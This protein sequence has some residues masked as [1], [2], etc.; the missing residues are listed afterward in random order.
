MRGISA[1]AAAHP[2]SAILAL[3]RPLEAPKPDADEE[4]LEGEREDLEEPIQPRIPAPPLRPVLLS[5]HKILRLDEGESP[6]ALYLVAEDSKLKADLMDL[7]R[8]GCLLRLGRLVEVRLNAQAEVDFRVRGLPFL[9]PG[10]TKEMRDKRT[11]EVRFSEMSRRKREE[12]AQVIEE[13][14]AVADKKAQKAAGL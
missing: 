14:I 10:S 7:S 11:I 5:Q 8:D 13:L 4:E 1:Q 3:K 9:L 12:L 6:A 2:E